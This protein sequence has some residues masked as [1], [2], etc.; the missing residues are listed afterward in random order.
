MNKVYMLIKFG[1]LVIFND[2]LLF[3]TSS[4]IHYDTI[5]FGI[6]FRQKDNKLVAENYTENIEVKQYQ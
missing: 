4:D 6:I 1:I 5:H 2:I 3:L